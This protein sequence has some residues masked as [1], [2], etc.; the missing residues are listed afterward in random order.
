LF[1]V[2]FFLFLEGKKKEVDLKRIK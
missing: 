1:S 2:C